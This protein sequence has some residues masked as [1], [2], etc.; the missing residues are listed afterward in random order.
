[1]SRNAKIKIMIILN[2]LFFLTGC[3]DIRILEDQAMIQ[4]I[5]YDLEKK[6]DDSKVEE[7]N[8]S[9][10]IPIAE[11]K[12]KQK[13]IHAKAGSSKEARLKLSSQTGWNL[14]NGQLRTILIGKSLAGLGVR[15]HLDALERDPSIGGRTKVAIVNGDA[16]AMLSTDYDKQQGTYEYID[17]LIEKEVQNNTFPGLSLYHFETDYYDDGVDP[18]APLLIKKKT[19]VGVDGIALFQDD[20]YVT[21]IDS[22]RAII[23]SLIHQELDDGHIN[24]RWTGNKEADP[25]FVAFSN[26]KSSRKLNVKHD[27]KSKDFTVNISVKVKGSILEYLGN[28]SIRENE[29]RAYI[30]RKLEEYLEHD[31]ERLVAFTQRHN[32][33]SFGL[34]KAVRN[35]LDYEEWKSLNWRDVYPTVKVNCKATVEIRDYGLVK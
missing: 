14:V 9:V 31:M 4:T 22:T 26:V 8:V 35:S 18:V 27:P 19:Y 16:A 30:E 20:R 11:E 1:M 23:F 12:G 3:N 33:D 15:T 2:V 24:F 25:E 21:K 29:N 10:S 32:V 5:T 28:K 7:I 6:N 34:G 17:R 13:I